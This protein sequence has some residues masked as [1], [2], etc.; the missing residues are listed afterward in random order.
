MMDSGA[1]ESVAPP[2]VWPSDVSLPF[3]GF[4]IWPNLP[5]ANGTSLANRGEQKA[6]CDHERLA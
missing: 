6:E 5:T 1:A 3:Q 4:R 2:S